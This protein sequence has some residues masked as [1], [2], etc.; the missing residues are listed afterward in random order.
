LS[1]QFSN[2]INGPEHEETTYNFSSTE[3]L[4]VMC[5]IEALSAKSESHAQKVVHNAEVVTW[6]NN[7]VAIFPTF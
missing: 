1:D 7:F 5:F 6:S 2:Y 3:S 4:G